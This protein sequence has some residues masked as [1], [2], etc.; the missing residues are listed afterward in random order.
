MIR[1]YEKSKTGTYKLGKVSSVEIDADGLVRTC[2]VTYR[3]V[4]SDLPPEELRFY[5]KGLKYKEIRVPVQRLCMILPVEEQENSSFLEKE[6]NVKTRRETM[7]NVDMNVGDIVSCSED[8]RNSVN[9]GDDVGFY[10]NV[11]LND[12]DQVAAR[13]LLMQTYRGSLVRQVKVKQS[14]L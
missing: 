8:R 7:E 13:E 10:D 3:L 11:Q 5:Y 2:T 1:Y 12:P 9:Q 6:N 14:D 4:R